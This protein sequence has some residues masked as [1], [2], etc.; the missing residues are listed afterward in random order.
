M[1]QAFR[2]MTGALRQAVVDAGLEDKIRTHNST[3]YN[4]KQTAR[5]Y[6]RRFNWEW[7]LVKRLTNAE[8]NLFLK[9][10]DEN[11]KPYDL[12]IVEAEKSGP[13][14]RYKGSI[15]IYVKSGV[16]TN[17]EELRKKAKELGYRLV[18]I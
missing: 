18:K 17:V 11:L 14:D 3:I 8:W 6:D 4:D 13:S 16:V 7:C 10:V 1:T 2:G 5:K 15:Y 12:T 9:Q